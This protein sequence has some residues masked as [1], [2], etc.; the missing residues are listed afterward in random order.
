[1]ADDCG[2]NG[3]Y[4]HYPTQN[5]PTPADMFKTDL[6]QYCKNAA[7]YNHKF[8]HGLSLKER[9]LDDLEKGYKTGSLGNK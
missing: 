8:A 2:H 6:I 3:A 9:G 4:C 7:D 5:T 1:M